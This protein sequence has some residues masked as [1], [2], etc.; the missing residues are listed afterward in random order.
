M[1]TR[2]HDLRRSDRGD[3][4]VEVAIGAAALIV[5]FGLAIVAM[6]I[7]TAESA[8]AEAARSAARSA[9]LA[10][11]GETAAAA[12]RQRATDVLAQQHLSCSG[13][14]IDVDA[15]DFAKPL[16]ETGF[17]IA[18]VT[19]EVGYNDLLIPGMSG[20]RTTRAEFRSPIDRHGARQ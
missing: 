5:L 2:L 18:T 19:C 16:G 3:M 8:I 10:H 9:S 14:Q 1:T 11:D 15:H 7:Q 4:N 13:L 20:S 6:R 12:A 17:V